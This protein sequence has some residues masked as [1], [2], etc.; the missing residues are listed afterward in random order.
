MDIRVRNNNLLHQPTSI[1]VNVNH[2]AFGETHCQ[3]DRLYL[4]FFDVAQE[5]NCIYC[6]KEAN[7]FF[8]ILAQKRVSSS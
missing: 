4:V 1:R 7:I 3:N 6:S 8:Q 5:D 2:T